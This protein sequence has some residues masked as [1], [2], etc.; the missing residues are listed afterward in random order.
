MEVCEVK[1]DHGTVEQEITEKGHLDQPLLITSGETEAQERVGC[2]QDHTPG[3]IGAYPREG[4]FWTVCVRDSSIRL[5]C[6]HQDGSVSCV[7]NPGRPGDN[8]ISSPGSALGVTEWADC[9]SWARVEEMDTGNDI[10]VDRVC[11]VS[12]PARPGHISES[13]ALD[14][15]SRRP[16]LCALVWKG[17]PGCGSPLSACAR[18]QDPLESPG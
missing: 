3:S 15:T 6:P 14:G 1:N 18:A 2:V 4:W 17:K 11:I 8:S 10:D 7:P 16:G 12:A 13:Q 9:H 5:N